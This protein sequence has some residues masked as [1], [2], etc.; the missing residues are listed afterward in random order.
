MTIIDAHHHVWDLS[1]RDQPWLSGPG[2]AA[3]RRSFSLADLRPSTVASTPAA[4][5]LGRKSA[6]EKLRLIAAIPGPLSQGW[7]LTDRS[8]T[9]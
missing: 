7:S 9:W 3:I 2:M 8:Q 1:V 4:R 5:A 6:S